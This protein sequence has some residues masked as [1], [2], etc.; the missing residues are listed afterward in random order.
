MTE[1]VIWWALAKAAE[2]INKAA[3]KLAPCREVDVFPHRNLV[4]CR[5]WWHLDAYASAV[6]GSA[7]RNVSI[8][9]GGWTIDASWKTRGELAA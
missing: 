5:R 1:R 8:E 3:A 2:G 6:P 4:K 7:W 9:V